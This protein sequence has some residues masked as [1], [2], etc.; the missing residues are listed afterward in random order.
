M[1]RETDDV[2]NKLFAE[3]RELLN[4]KD[5]SYEKLVRL[6]ERFSGLERSL[7]DLKTKFESY[8]T[9]HEFHP[10]RL[11]AYGLAGLVLCGV[12]SAIIASVI[13]K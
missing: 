9:Q 7:S 10:V 1:S 13:S 2:A 11:L 8:V 6:E 12:F 3:L 5:G 4:K